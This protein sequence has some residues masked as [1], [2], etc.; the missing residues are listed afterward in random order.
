MAEGTSPLAR[1]GIDTNPS[2]ALR[3]RT[4][5]FLGM[6]LL[7]GAT[8]AGL[9]GSVRADEPAVLGST[10]VNFH[11]AAISP[12]GKR[13]ATAHGRGIFKLWDV[14]T[15]KEMATLRHDASLATLCLA[16][17]PDS[18]VLACG[19][20]NVKE[21]RAKTITLWEAE[22]GKALPPLEGSRMGY[23]Q[24][25]AF[26]PDGCVL[27]SVTPSFLKLWD[28]KTHKIRASYEMSAWDVQFSPDGKSLALACSNSLCFWDMAAEKEAGR[29]RGRGV[30][31]QRVR[32]APDGRS[33][34]TSG[35]S[36]QLWD[37]QGKELAFFDPEDHSEKIVGAAFS[38]RGYLLATGSIRGFLQFRDPKSL[39]VLASQQAHSKA[40]THVVF[41]PDGKRVLTVS[42]DQYL[43][44]WDVDAILK[45]GEGKE[46]AP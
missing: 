38:P 43:K 42:A 16:F 10:E 46:P 14:E 12:D 40:V 5:Y 15:R 45:R 21:P 27:A 34:L 23:I 24:G 30:Y 17:S 3:G 32:Y 39:K 31:L 37:L 28:L 6:A 11:M 36:L 7:C 13:V 19:S 26:S 2:R 1:P 8:A 25:L 44:V 9:F 18:K 22:T 33:V 4:A 35:G 41:T 29:F 20:G